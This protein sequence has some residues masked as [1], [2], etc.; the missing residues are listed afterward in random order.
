MKYIPLLPI[1]LIFAGCASAPT[2]KTTY[3]L[4]SDVIFESRE[5]QHGA[6]PVSLGRIEVAN[7]LAQPGVVMTDADGV[8]HVS[9]YNL[10]AE[11]LQ[12]SLRSFLAMELSAALQEDISLE[13][14][15]SRDGLRLDVK[16]DQLHG[17]SH[18][19]AVLVAFWSYELD[20]ETVEFQYNQRRPLKGEGYAALVAAQQQVL[21]GLA[22]EIG[23]ELSA[24]RQKAAA[25]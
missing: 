10:W 3:L 13:T 24:Q 15:R 16:I 4:R 8:I 11:P 18:G 25:L 6:V 1:C 21:S 17:D 7:Y 2:P 9:N 22:H 12:K 23:S 5:L 14:D 20:G 19:Y